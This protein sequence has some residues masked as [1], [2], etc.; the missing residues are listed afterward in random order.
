MMKVK[1]I[2]LS[3]AEVLILETEE[4]FIISGRQRL[5]SR[6]VRIFQLAMMIAGKKIL[7]IEDAEKETE[8][9]GRLNEADLGK[10]ARAFGIFNYSKERVV[11]TFEKGIFQIITSVKKEKDPEELKAIKNYLIS[12]YVPLEKNI[13]VKTLKEMEV[14]MYRT[15]ERANIITIGQ[16]LNYPPASLT[17]IRNIGEKTVKEIEKKLEK[18]GIWFRK[19]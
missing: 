18:E 15:L 2:N 10:I 9:L 4:K 12:E 6:D 1:G 13:E 17:K 5:T 8:K 16:L 11:T 3:Q 19:D 7:T 14:P